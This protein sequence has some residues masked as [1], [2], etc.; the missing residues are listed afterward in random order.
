MISLTSFDARQTQSSILS[1]TPI[2]SLGI[3]ILIEAQAQ[4]IAYQ[5]E[6][7]KEIEG[8]VILAY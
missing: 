1:L 6:G 2:I 4:N 5:S 8:H 3:L 7:D